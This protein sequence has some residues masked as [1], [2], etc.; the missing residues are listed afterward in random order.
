MQEV[1]SLEVEEFLENGKNA[2]I[3]L[4]N[5]TF[6]FADQLVRTAEMCEQYL[7]DVDPDYYGWDRCILKVY[8]DSGSRGEQKDIKEEGRHNV[9]FRVK[10]IR[11]VGKC[12]W[13]IHRYV[14]LKNFNQKE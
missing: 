5:I 12:C 11:T 1:E 4:E 10:S 13:I 3:L 8:S 6:F 9:G 2:S 14:Y 7:N